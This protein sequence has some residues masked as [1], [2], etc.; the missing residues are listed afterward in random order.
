MF[1][2]MALEAA[3]QMQ[4]ESRS[5][6]SSLVV[7]NVDFDQP[8]QLHSIPET[9]PGLE[10]KLIAKHEESTSRFRFEIVSVESDS[11]ETSLRH[12]TGFFGWQDNTVADSE[13]AACDIVHDP[14]L[15]DCWKALG[16]TVPDSLHQLRAG[17]EGCAGR[18][19]QSLN[20]Y[21]NYSIDPRVLDDILS[22][23]TLPLIRRTLPAIYRLVSVESVTGQILNEQSSVGD[24][25]VNLQ[26]EY[27]FGARCDLEI[28][29]GGKSLSLNGLRYQA[30]EP[31]IREPTPRPLFFEAVSMPDISYLAPFTLQ[32]PFADLA[33]L[34]SHKW[35][36]SDNRIQ[37]MS[38]EHTQIILDE[39]R[40]YDKDQR[41]M[42]RSITIQGPKPQHIAHR[43]GYLED[44]D[45]SQHYH[46]LLTGHIDHPQEV[47]SQLP[48]GGLVCLFR[49]SRQKHREIPT[50]FFE[51][52]AECGHGHP[53]KFRWDVWR[54]VPSVVQIEGHNVV[55]FEEPPSETFPRNTLFRGLQ[56]QVEK[57]PLM[58][59]AVSQFCQ[60]SVHSRI[61]AIVIDLKEKSVIASWPGEV[62]IPWMQTLLKCADS[63]LWVTGPNSTSPSY[64]L[65]GT[66]LR[67]LQSEQPSLKVS[68][69]TVSGKAK[70]DTTEEK[71]LKAY[72]S[73]LEGDNE[74]R[75][76]LNGLQS[77]VRYYPDDELSIGTGLI[78]PRKFPSR[79][80]KAEGPRFV[81][82]SEEPL[83][84][85]NYAVSFTAPGK[86]VIL[87]S[88]SQPQTLKYGETQIRIHA[89]IVHP[90]ELRGFLG[91]GPRNAL[92]LTPCRFFAG[93]I[94]TADQD[95]GD[96]CTLQRI[97]G[98]TTVS[99]Q[100]DIVVP[101]SQTYKRFDDPI[102]QL[103]PPELCCEFA[104]VAVAS[105]IVDGVARTRE[106]DLFELRLDGVLKVALHQLITKAG[107]S[108]INATNAIKAD[109]TVT[110]SIAEGVLVN[111]QPFDLLNYLQSQRGQIFVEQAWQSR[112]LLSCPLQSFRISHIDQAFENPVTQSQPYS[113]A[114]E[115][116]QGQEDT[117]THVPIYIPPTTLFSSAGQYV[118]IGGLGGL[119]RFICT[120]MVEHGA[121]NLVAISRS[122]LSSPEAHETQAAI[123]ALGTSLQVF[124]ADACDRERMQSILASLRLEAPIKGVINLAMILGDAPMASMTG[125]EWDRALKVKI[126][127]SWILHEETMEDELDFFILFSS[128]ASVCGNRNQG[129]YNVGNTFLNAL[130]EYR[131]SLDRPGISIALGAMSK[132]SIVF[133]NI[134]H[135]PAFHSQPP[136]HPRS[137][138]DIGTLADMGV[139]YSLS[140]TNMLDILTRSGLS[141]LTKTHLAKIMEAAILESSRR[142]R[143]LIVTGLEMFERD[144]AGKLKGR[145]EPLFW[146]EL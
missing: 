42:C 38:N 115:H 9:E 78:P 109:F 131:Q 35:P 61:D 2:M 20:P 142:D 125:E 139:L 39:F 85:K 41:P 75:R 74:I 44:F 65:A 124:A 128:I 111:D 3:R 73:M 114:I 138:T 107:A 129:N 69:L 46:V 87:S 116:V 143:S 103:H 130:A 94:S 5:A 134:A 106:G 62:F 144:T 101:E 119:G 122:G 127:S 113:T 1:L 10:I 89:S 45:P 76:D 29:H 17:S 60:R 84:G 31:L 4:A 71:I 77:V 79:P 145:A 120:W 86:P 37:K 98:Y 6:A 16:N 54:K 82:H 14:A 70:L 52:A 72:A 24:F 121:Q 58:L 25:A 40:A 93:N 55:L 117:L 32:I 80:P 27:P 26:S 23:G 100:K 22:I 49:S 7:S 133:Y 88:R 28:C 83:S 137:S 47:Y 92:K 96:D 48:P 105:C 102:M 36:M 81:D 99:I 91:S 53:K 95:V 141:H 18:F 13:I 63:L 19:E 123:T 15:L 132:S 50:E 146:A 104:T 33:R 64:Q 57:I 90:E 118:L 30:T 34:I 51:R 126:D 136:Q 140:K 68:W 112:R 67:A 59:P 11:V 66:L 56:N 43:A 97:V 8:L 12:C 135:E 110:Y 108:V 21:D